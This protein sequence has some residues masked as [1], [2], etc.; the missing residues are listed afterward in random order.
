[1]PVKKGFMSPQNVFIENIIRKFDGSREYIYIL[2]IQMLN[3]S[4]L[5]CVIH[6]NVNIC[7]AERNF[8]L[9]N[10]QL[11]DIPIVYS[12]DGFCALTGYKRTELLQNSTNCDFLCGQGTDPAAVQTIREALRGSDEKKVQVLY[13]KKNGRLLS[14]RLV[15]ST[16]TAAD[17]SHF[18]FKVKKQFKW[19]ES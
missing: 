4:Q 18:N 5:R 7:L 19:L 2:F 15:M 16:L 10:A 13:Y 12:N 3:N 8:I 11:V 17:I 6:L 14:K 1:M 9:G